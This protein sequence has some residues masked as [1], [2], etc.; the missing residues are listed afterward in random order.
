MYS[1]YSNII[2]VRGPGSETAAMH[3]CTSRPLKSVVN[4]ICFG[5]EFRENIFAFWDLLFLKWEDKIAHIK[6]TQYALSFNLNK[7]NCLMHYC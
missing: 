1:R 5:N 2:K 7:L 4:G 3:I 6:Y